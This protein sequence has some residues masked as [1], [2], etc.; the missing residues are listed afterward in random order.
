MAAPQIS[1]EY[2][3]DAP[4]D[5]NLGPLIGISL[6]ALAFVVV[7]VILLAGMV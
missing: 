7:E 3:E 1:P 6:F 4:L 2:V 5:P